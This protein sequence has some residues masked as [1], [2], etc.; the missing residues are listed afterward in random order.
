MT[1][2]EEL[3]AKGKDIV[4]V[5]TSLGVLN[6]DLETYMPPKGA[7]QRGAQIGMLS[8]I[9]HRMTIDPALRKLIEKVDKDTLSEVDQRDFYL[10]KKNYDEA[11]KLPEKLV[12]DIAEQQ[13]A[14][15]VTWRRAKAASDWKMFE[16]ELKKTIELQIQRAEILQDIKGT[17]NIYDTMIDD[18]EPQTT[19]DE[20]SRVFDQLKRGL[21]P[22]VQK[23]SEITA[24]VDKS[25]MK[26]TIPKEIQ[27]KIAV[28]LANA[29]G[30]DTT[31]DQAG[32]RIDEV[33]H[34]FT[35]G[36]Y[37]DVRITVKYHEDNFA[38]AMY[39]ILHEAGHALYEQNLNPDWKFRALGTAASMGIHESQSRWVENMIGRSPQFLEYY[40][41]KL[42]DITN[43]AFSKISTIDFVKAVNTVQPSKI[44]I[45]ADEVT[46]CLHIIIRFEI[47]RDLLGG[48]IEVSDLP[49]IWNQKY[50]E[51]LGI[52]IEN[53]AE[54]V[55]Q[56]VHW[57]F[58]YYGYFPTYALGNIYDGMWY[59]KITEE[60]P[61]WQDK[62]AEGEVT[63][64]IEW[65][66]KNIHHQAN[67]H[68]PVDL[69]KLVTGKNL[70]AKPFLK[71]IDEKYSAIYE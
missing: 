33:E 67:R 28:E 71:Y 18:Y 32:G 47:E 11:I 25:F 50:S 40:L 5:G 12:A 43:G 1:A 62:L 44:R 65:M 56:D 10:V 30:Y 23:Y 21:I 41:P 61:D 2:F 49:N 46:Y 13:T 48:K 66:K 20:I 19:A 39:A 53:D 8:K 37:D 3:L 34:P 58:G 55:L 15:S 26:K 68:F 38:S 51:Y 59:D 36:Y 60:I 6:W 7:R 54:G 27:Q 16:P 31:S 9:V 57:S 24:S 42:N 63:T 22:L 52:D 64:S 45:E 35:N 29:V 69:A 70:T 17:D 14:S 4:L